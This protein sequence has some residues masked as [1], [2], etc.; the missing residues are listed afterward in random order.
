[1]I[2]T[3]FWTVLHFK[4]NNLQSKEGKETI[5]YIQIAKKWAMVIGS[6]WNWTRITTGRSLILLF[7]SGPNLTFLTMRV[8]MVGS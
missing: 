7:L 1:M 3:E 2:H 4:N 8:I 5:A 6:G